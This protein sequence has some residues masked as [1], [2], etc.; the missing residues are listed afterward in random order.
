MSNA[1]RIGL[2]GLG[3]VGQSAV[4]I[5]DENRDRIEARAGGP[6]EIVRAVVRDTTRKR[7]IPKH[8]QLTTCFEQVVGASDVDIVVEVMG[9]KKPATDL[10]LK[11]LKGGQPIVT[12][13]KA[14]IAASADR[15]F[16]LARDRGVDVQFEASVAGGIPIVRTLR[17][18]LVSDQ[19]T[20]I[21]GI[22]NGT[23][24]YM[25]QA[26]AHGRSYEVALK[27][28]QEKGYAEADPT[29]D[30]EGNDAADKLA[31]LM[32][33]GFGVSVKPNRIETQ[34]I[35]NLPVEV[36]QDAERMG[37]RV[38]LV[39]EALRGRGGEIQGSVAPQFVAVGHQLST[40][41]G[42]QNAIFVGSRSLGQTVY[43]GL[44]AGAAATGSAVVADIIEVARALRSGANGVVT[45]P[46][47]LPGEFF[48][49]GNEARAA[50]YIRL[51]VREK[52][53]V[54][55][56]LAGILAKEGISIATLNQEEPELNQDGVE[57]VLTTHP[58]R[59]GDMKLALGALKR[60]TMKGHMPCVLRIYSEQG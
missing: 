28:A 8:V 39:A 33:L 26:M 35:T 42:A 36:F 6:L 58:A 10:I 15:I 44:G 4:S 5:I 60:V 19:V 23:T 45:L 17:N 30:V 37:Y 48:G 51:L 55:A 34:G 16:K 53:G 24:N 2:L 50:F 40:I 18:A 12:A 43:Q 56:S 1:I 59:F 13:N 57:I 3:T 49:D 9:G 47:V 11:A 29:L 41:P 22:L 32:R 27:E 38:K 25:L 21:R 31:I 14:V 20:S 54:L 7:N 52:P 46:E